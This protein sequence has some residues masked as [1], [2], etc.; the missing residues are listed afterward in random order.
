MLA[1]LNPIGRSIAGLHPSM[2]AFLETVV[3]SA[4]TQRATSL[5]LPFAMPSHM[6]VELVTDTHLRGDAV[7]QQEQAV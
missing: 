4:A 3:E 6:P 2:V 1:N 5:I 7:E